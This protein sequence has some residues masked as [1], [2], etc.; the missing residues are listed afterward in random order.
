MTEGAGRAA[1]GLDSES[2]CRFEELTLPHLGSMYQLALRLTGNTATAE[3]LVQ[4]SYL[5][6][7]TAFASLRDPGRVRPWLFQILSRLVFDRRRGEK[8]EMSRAREDLDRFSLY[9][10]IW[11]E[12]PMP[13]SDRLHDDFLAQ[14]RDEE[15]RAALRALPEAYRIPLVLLHVEELSYRDLAEILGCP[16]GTVMSRLHRGRKILERELW[17][18][19]KRR[20]LVKTWKPRSG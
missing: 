13:Y 12:D 1:V 9:D 14:F 7:L 4:E 20:G 15:V 2:R 18:C 16:I 5:K 17:E 6:A 8:R 11:E 19:A 3:D 10:R